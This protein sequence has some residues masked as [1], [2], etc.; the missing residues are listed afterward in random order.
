MT[1]LID[2][3]PSP[4]DVTTLCTAQLPTLKFHEWAPISD[5]I[6]QYFK[7]LLHNQVSPQPRSWV[8]LPSIIELANFFNCCEM[9]VFDALYAL[10]QE[11]YAY[12]MFGIDGPIHLCDP[13]RRVKAHVKPLP[14]FR[15]D[16][17]K[18]LHDARKKHSVEQRFSQWDPT[19]FA[20]A[21]LALVI[22]LFPQ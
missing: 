2:Q 20:M 6:A 3:G 8:H 13:L 5:Q 11:Q 4:D 14:R 17:L 15:K 1:S 22:N 9:D 21:L 18:S 7:D 10:K 12:E 16:W 19:K